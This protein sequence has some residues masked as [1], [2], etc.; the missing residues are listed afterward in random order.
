[1]D[2]RS[3]D[4]CRR[5]IEDLSRRSGREE[6]DVALA[7]LRLASERSQRPGTDPREGTVGYF[8]IGDG[9]SKLEKET[10]YLPTW[11][12]RLERYVLRRA[13]PPTR[14]SAVHPGNC[15]GAV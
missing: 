8:L 9:R 3:R 7:A 5:E 10:H 4:L 6:Q 11:R 1:M 12:R 2:F 14:P 15:V 13:L